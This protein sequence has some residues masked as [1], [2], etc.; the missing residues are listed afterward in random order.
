MARLRVRVELSRGGQGVPLHKL[1][2]VIDDALKF[3]QM[4]GEDAGIPSHSGEWLG[5]D[6]DRDTLNFTAEYVGPVTRSQVE[7]FHAG[8]AG[9]TSLRRATIAQFARITETI[10]EEELVGFGLYEADAEEVMAG[11]MKSADEPTEWRCISRR[12]ALRM[13]EEIDLLAGEEVPRESHLPTVR[14]PALAARLFGERRDRG[15]EHAKWADY[16][17]D[18]ET[19]LSTRLANVETTVQRHSEILEDM[20]TRTVTAEESFRHLLT[21]VENFCNQAAQQIERLPQVAA[22]PAPSFEV[23]PIG[24]TPWLR[25]PGP[26]LAVGCVLGVL[27]ASVWVWMQPSSTTATAAP[28]RT[29]QNPPLAPARV[30]AQPTPAIPAST[31]VAKAAVSAQSAPQPVNAQ[32]PAP[33][34]AAPE[35]GPSMHL[36]LSATEP[37]WVALNDAN[38]NRLL[39]QLLVPGSPRSVQLE[40]A[41]TLRVGNA[42]GIEIRLDGKSIGS[43]GPHG[44]VKQIEF[45]GGAFRIFDGSPMNRAAR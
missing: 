11:E 24:S 3:F 17:R 38:G 25:R 14:D 26:A 39:A 9:T 34:A 19:G 29:S 15:L 12:D 37:T 30:E 43:V 16:V 2:H 45:K 18:M 7:A 13:T 20:R 5:V 36:D 44:G 22:L 10:A 4:L 6:F 33:R 41:A 23:D 21:A 8:F 31:P 1:A 27:I 32:T 42:G 35:S 28:V 40:T